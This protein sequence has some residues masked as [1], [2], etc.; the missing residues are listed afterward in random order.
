MESKEEPE[1]TLKLPGRDKKARGDSPFWFLEF[2]G[3]PG[4]PSGSSPTSI[5]LELQAYEEP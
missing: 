4:H 2:P 5:E 3:P 1:G